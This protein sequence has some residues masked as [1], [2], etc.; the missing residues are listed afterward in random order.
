MD[1]TYN[2]IVFKTLDM[3]QWKKSD[4]QESENKCGQDYCLEG[5]PGPQCRVQG[6]EGTR[7]T[8]MASLS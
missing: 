8:P 7:Q 6:G 4:L 1:T 2:I 3:K 5:V